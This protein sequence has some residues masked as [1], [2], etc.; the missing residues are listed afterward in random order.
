MLIPSFNLPSNPGAEIRMREATVADCIALADIAED[1]EEAA[2]TFFLD[3]VTGGDTKQWTA[4]DRRFA[5]LWY[6]VHVEQEHSY[7]VEYDCAHCGQTHSFHFDL[8]DILDTYRP[9]DGQPFRDI[10]VRGEKIRVVPLSGAAVEALELE[11][12]GLDAA[13]AEH[14]PDSVE[15][16]KARLQMRLNELI[17]RTGIDEQKLVGLPMGNLQELVSAVAEATDEMAHGLESV[18]DTGRIYFLSPEHECPETKEVTRC[19]V[20]FWASEFIPEL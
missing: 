18:Y 11:R 6:F 2:T 17:H 9:I 19:R 5:L 14:G 13:E 16:R 1:R 10:T 3:A 12:I 20:R 8:K 7:R 15:A 4:E